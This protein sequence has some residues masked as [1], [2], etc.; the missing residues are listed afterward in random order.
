MLR[1]RRRMTSPISAA[2]SFRRRQR[3]RGRGIF[4]R[5]LRVVQIQ[6]WRRVN[7]FGVVTAHRRGRDRDHGDLWCSCRRGIPRRPIPVSVRAALLTFSPRR[8]RFSRSGRRF[9][10]EPTGHR[11]QQQQLGP[12][13]ITSRSPRRRHRNGQLHDAVPAA[14]GASVHDD[15]DV[16]TDGGRSRSGRHPRRQ[17]VPSGA[18]GFCKSA[19][20]ASACEM[21]PMRNLIMSSSLCFSYRRR[22]ECCWRWST[23]RRLRARAVF[24]GH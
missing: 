12:L 8:W 22:P 11:H 24:A 15:R 5:H 16:W 10:L 18:R 13:G 6:P 20:M 7:G 23:H 9:E 21:S 3:P 17:H 19:V 4:A 14:A 1:G 2:R